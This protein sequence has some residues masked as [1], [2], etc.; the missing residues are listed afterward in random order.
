MK[1]W[2]EQER[3]RD[4]F[5]A[6]EN[7]KKKKRQVLFGVHYIVNTKRAKITFSWFPF[8]FTLSELWKHPQTK[9][10]MNICI[11][12]NIKGGCNWSFRILLK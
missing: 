9:I 7:Q 4:H 11:Y 12:S 8:R 2:C 1:L 3:V 6:K 10:Q 5:S